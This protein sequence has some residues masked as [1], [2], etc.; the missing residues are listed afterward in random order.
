MPVRPSFRAVLMAGLLAV[1][2]PVSAQQY[3]NLRDADIRAF[4]EDAARVTGRNIIVDPD[5][6]GTVSVITEQPLSRAQYFEVFL[7]TLRANDLVAIPLSGGGL[8]ISNSADAARQPAVASDGRFVTRVVR[9]EQVTAAQALE[10]V[11]PLISAQGQATASGTGNALVIADYQDNLARVLA[12]LAEVDRDDST[13]RLV[14]LSNAGAR[15]IA[16][17]L[18]ELARAGGDTAVSVVPVDSSN[19]VILRGDPQRVSQLAGIVA[20]LDARAALGADVRVFYLEHADAQLLLPV[21]QQI[22]GQTTSVAT[23]DVEADDG[24]PA[25][26]ANVVLPASG[27]RARA[28][29]ARYEGANALIVSAAPDLQRTLGEVI[30]QLDQRREQ[31]LVEA[32]VAEVSDNAARALGVEFLL[33]GLD[34][35]VP[36]ASTNYSNSVLNPLA[37]AGAVGATQLE[38]QTITVDGEVISQTGTVGITDSLQQAAAQSL[39]G[40]SGGLFGVGGVEGDTVFGA[41]LNA[42]K[43]DTT[44][45]ILSVQSLMTLDNQVARYLVGQEVPVTTGE[46]LSENFDN[47][48]RTVER[49]NV[50]IQL[51]VRPQINAGGAVKLFL[52]QEVSSIAGPVSSGSADLVLNT[53]EIETTITVD[54]GDIVALGGLLDENERK[55]IEKIPLLGDIP[56]LGELFT[57][58][59]REQVQ[60]NLMVFIRPRIIRSREDAQEIAAQRYNYQRASQL[61]HDPD[62]EPA[63]DRVL[64]TYLDTVPPGAVAEGGGF[65]VDLAG[66][67]NAE[68]AAAAQA[69]LGELGPGTIVERGGAYVLRLGPVGS[70]EEAARL[71]GEAVEAGFP[72]ADILP[73]AP[74]TVTTET[75]S[76]GSAR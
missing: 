30:R 52:K 43:S 36:F 73:L 62:S 65:A 31:V 1:A 12:V 38:N 7:E 69:R 34:G 17:A 68:D 19:S 66:Y 56:V 11:A 23:V 24:E 26:A 18:G 5:V 54:D 74:E 15:E 60:T 4:I 10:A 46:A 58:R 61:A 9:L 67:A 55:T 29:I 6:E 42:V 40:V 59:S 32:I 14:P 71:R 63:L 35:T 48:F 37:I 2:G 33:A 13:I 16:A 45:N 51:E 3:L 47:A 21:L 8:R 49:Q 72:R 57:S 75:Y 27:E 44:S 39:L 41:I 76:G 20:E 50:G 64:R 28:V 70:A 53:R 22:A 25:G